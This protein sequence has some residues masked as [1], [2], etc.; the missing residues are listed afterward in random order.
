MKL[1]SLPTMVHELQA[2]EPA[3]GHPYGE[4]RS[5]F[6]LAIVILIICISQTLIVSS[7]FQTVWFV[8]EGCIERKLGNRQNLLYYKRNM[9]T[10]MPYVIK[11]LSLQDINFYN[12]FKSLRILDFQAYTGKSTR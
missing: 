8:E 12:L 7:K 5:R 9:W 10:G 6:N 3:Y 2:P 11:Q 1:E 4:A